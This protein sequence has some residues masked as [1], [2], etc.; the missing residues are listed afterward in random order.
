VPAVL[1]P[2]LAVVV[3]FL[4]DLDALP[5]AV[6]VAAFRVVAEALTNVTRHARAA[7]CRVRVHRGSSLHIEVVDDG[8]GIGI[9]IGP[10]GRTAWGSARCA[11]GPQN[12]AAGA[13]S[14]G[15]TRAPR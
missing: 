2:D 15:R 6:E 11:S 1:H 8:I 9:G 13:R 10:A 12:S 3:Q 4:G 5:A 7:T 14:P